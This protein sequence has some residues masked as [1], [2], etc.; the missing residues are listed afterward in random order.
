MV[1][2]ACTNGLPTK[3]QLRQKHVNI[4]CICPSCQVERESI[5]HILI[6]CSFAKAC[7]VKTGITV[8]SVVQGSFTGCLDS[9]LSQ[10]EQEKRSIAFMT[11]WA[12]WKARNDR[13]W[14]KSG[15]TVAAV[16]LMAQSCLEQWSKAQVNREICN[17]AFLSHADGMEYWSRPSLFFTKINVDAS[18]FEI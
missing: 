18:L 4:D 9:I 12:I 5:S 14:N 6:E 15:I 13:V 11:C 10:A 17:A 2:R 16:T 1:W 7:W 8:S 3:V